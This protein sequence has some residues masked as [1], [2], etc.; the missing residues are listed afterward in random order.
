MNG[1]VVEVHSCHTD[2]CDLLF[3]LTLGSHPSWLQ[4]L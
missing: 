3:L 4:S 2:T 1:L